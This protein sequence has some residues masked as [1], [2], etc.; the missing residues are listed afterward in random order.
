MS[1]I[2]PVITLLALGLALAAGSAVPGRATAQEVSPPPPK[3]YGARVGY[4]TGPDQ[5]VIGAQALLG[6]RL[7]FL[8]FAPSFDLGWGDDV[9]TYVFNGDLELH[10]GL[11]RTRSHF[12]LG[13]GV[14]VGAFDSDVET[15]S[16]VGLNLSL[17]TRLATRGRA[18]YNIE[19][20]FGVGELPD[21]RLLVGMLF[22]IGTPAPGSAP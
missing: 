2:R 9:T 20:R 8:R 21:F 18:N 17:G 4:G 13:A 1:S 3:G 16:G 15:D 12:Y 19:G 10:L 14:G 7:G 22:G 11:P 6:E 5:F